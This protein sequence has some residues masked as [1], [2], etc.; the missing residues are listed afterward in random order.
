M[1]PTDPLGQKKGAG[2]STLAGKKGCVPVALGPNAVSNVHGPSS[3]G[4]ESS[5]V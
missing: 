3:D 4:A 5:S 2:L 1:T